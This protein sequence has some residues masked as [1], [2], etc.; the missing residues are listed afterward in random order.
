MMKNKK[1]CMKEMTQNSNFE[2][3]R[4]VSM[5]MILT[6]HSRFED[7]VANYDG[8]IDANHVCKFFLRRCP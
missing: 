1:V 2:L 4:I 6:L 7:I 3:L 5:F 8:I